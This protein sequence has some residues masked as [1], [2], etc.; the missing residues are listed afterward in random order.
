MKASILDG[1]GKGDIAMNN[2]HKM[3]IHELMEIEWKVE[4]FI[5]HDMKITH[6]LGCFECWMKTPGICRFDDAGRKIAKSFIQSDLVIFLT[7][8]TFGGY[9]SELKKALDRIICL[10]LPF[11]KRYNGEVHHKMRYKKYPGFMVAGILPE[12][13]P[14]SERIFKTLVERNALNF[15]PPA[16]VSGFIYRYQSQEEIQKTI[17]TLLGVTETITSI[18]N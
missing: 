8:V 6:C 17:N 10:D 5:L 18:T 16:H 4:S 13:D 9:S 14:E 3:I 2:I 11:F 7:P 15:F 1:L 12:A